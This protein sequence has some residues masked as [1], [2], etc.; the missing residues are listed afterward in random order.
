MIKK[1]KREEGKKLTLW[2]TVNL[3]LQKVGCD[4]L[5]GSLAREDHCGVCNGNGKS[6]KII[7]GDFNHTRG[8]GN[9]FF[10]IFSELLIQTVFG[11]EEIT[12]KLT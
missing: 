12:L 5:L 6:C 7:K 11:N 2:S 4:G 10:L 9:Y 3:F 1:R 8:A